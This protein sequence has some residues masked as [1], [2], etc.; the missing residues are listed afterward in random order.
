MKM[1]GPTTSWFDIVERPVFVLEEIALG[2]DKY[3]DKSYAMVSHLF[4]KIW[5]CRYPR[6]LK[7]VFDNGSEFKREFT[8]LLKEF[9]IKPVLTL[10]YNP[11]T[12]TPVK[13]VHQ[14]IINMLVTKDLDNKVFDY[15]GTWGETLASIS[16]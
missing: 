7:V 8:P 9:D 2:N 15:I 4:N 16:W 10:V 5:L 1:I 14:V 3:I 11:Q 13:Q 12:N 6:P